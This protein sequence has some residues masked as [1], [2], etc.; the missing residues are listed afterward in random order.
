MKRIILISILL[1]GAMSVFA[2]TKDFAPS[3][4]ASIQ[5]DTQ[6]KLQSDEMQQITQQMARDYEAHDL[7]K[8]PTK[9]RR[10]AVMIL[11]SFSMPMPMIKRYALDA[12]KIGA[13]VVLRG[14]VNNNISD[15]GRFVHEMIGAQ[16]LGLNVDPIIFEKLNIHKVPAFVLLNDKGMAC[17]NDNTCIPDSND[18]A[19]LTG[20]VT[21]SYA[22]SQFANGD[23]ELAKRAASLLITLRERRGA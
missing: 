20:N 9:K 15:T 11:V 17:V 13:S 2:N 8:L 3:E 16:D 6:A 23:G 10:D 4:I 14:F 22:L 12:K 19:L 5:Q 21:L 18:Y 1:L 7:K